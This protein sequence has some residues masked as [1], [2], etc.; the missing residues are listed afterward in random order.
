MIYI[1]FVH[2]CR[3]PWL[4]FD[5]I[6]YLTKAGKEYKSLCNYIHAFSHRIIEERKQNLVSSIHY[7]I[8][9]YKISIFFR[10]WQCFLEILCACFVLLFVYMHILTSGGGVCLYWWTHKLTES[11]LLSLNF[12]VWFSFFIIIQSEHCFYWIQCFDWLFF[13]YQYK[14]C[15]DW[16]FYGHEY[17]T[18]FY[19]S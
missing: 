13:G 1:R 9:H 5:R 15:S 3:K 8:F 11:G 2:F 7:S 6:Y 10:I 12:Q 14:S 4:H 16:L 18:R 17:N 19:A